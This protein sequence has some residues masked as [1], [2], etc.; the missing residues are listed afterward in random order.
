VSVA[1]DVYL[2]AANGLHTARIDFEDRN[3]LQQFIPPS[4]AVFEITNDPF[5]AGENLIDRSFA[6][7]QFEVTRI[8]STTALTETEAE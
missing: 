3:R 2:G 5:F 8:G 4:F 6:D 7:I 1:F